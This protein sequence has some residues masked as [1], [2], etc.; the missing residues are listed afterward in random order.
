MAADPFATS[1]APG[2]DDPVGMLRACH[3]KMERQLAT[4]ARL[5]R[6]LPEHHAD[7]DACAAASALLRYF[8]TAAVNHHADEEA[9][10]FPRLREAD[11]GADAMVRSLE[12]DHAALTARWARLRPLLTAIAA[13]CSGYLPVKDVDEFCAAYAAHIAREEATLLPRAEAL[14]AAT[15]AKIG[16]EMALRRNA[17]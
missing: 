1:P 15:L 14:D 12:D 3:R 10:L 2:F 4:L 8:D 5:R 11:A 9:S 16:A 13:R 6:H 7:R 17:L